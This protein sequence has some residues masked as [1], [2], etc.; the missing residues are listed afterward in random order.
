MFE[1]YPDLVSIDEFA[2][3]FLLAEMWL[4]NF[5]EGKK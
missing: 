2:K 1:D 3:C 4:M 5:C